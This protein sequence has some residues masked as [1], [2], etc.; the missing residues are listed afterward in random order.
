MHW[1]GWQSSRRFVGADISGNAIDVAISGLVKIE[2]GHVDA[3]LLRDLG[4]QTDDTEA[5]EITIVE[6]I[7][8]WGE[9]LVI[10]GDRLVGADGRD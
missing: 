5:V 7:D 1:L 6:Q 8:S 9:V 10:G 3:E 2:A 4:D